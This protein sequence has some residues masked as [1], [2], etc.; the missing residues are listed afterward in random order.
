[1]NDTI[2]HEVP[3][4]GMRK[5]FTGLLPVLLACLLTTD[6][7]V[8]AQGQ[9]AIDWQDGPSTVR[10]AGLGQM[11]I[12][13]GYRF[14][15]AEGARRFSELM[16]NPPDGREIGVVIPSFQQGSTMEDFWF[17]I[18]SFDA[19]GYVKDDDKN[20]LDSATKSAILDSL[21]QGT[22]RANE[23]RREK[24]WTPL[25][26]INWQQEPF[27][28]FQSHNL[29]WALLC[30]SGGNQGINFNTRILCRTGVLSANLVLRP[31]LLHSSLPAYNSLIGSI[32]LNSEN[33]YGAFRAGDKVAEYGLV[34]LITGGVGTAAIKTGFFA[35][36]LKPILIG[37]FAA[38]AALF[39]KLKQIGKRIV[40]GQEGPST[41]SPTSN[42]AGANSR[43]PE[44]NVRSSQRQPTDE[45]PF[46]IVS[47]PHCGQKNRIPTSRLT[48]RPICGRCHNPVI[49]PQ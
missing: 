7:P 29:K 11:T 49:I 2:N 31:R 8:L 33:E 27:Y 28:D 26:V 42:A 44:Q 22:E 36:Y 12:P 10:L 19:I 4:P 6:R 24:G 30:S 34:A 40:S 15:G 17:I 46:V 43:Q 1:M 5:R 20:S 39:N 21:R 16:H 25:N 18:F 41:S 38:I 45:G 37:L 32:S 14:T 23:I 48:E 9:D 47:C 13:P 3:S 35:K